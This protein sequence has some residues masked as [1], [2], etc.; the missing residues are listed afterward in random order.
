MD[1][2]DDNTPLV[3]F[4]FE[5]VFPFKF[6]VSNWQRDGSHPDGFRYKLLSVRH[7]SEEIIELVLAREEADGTKT[8]VMRHPIDESIAHEASADLLKRVREQYSLDFE[9]Q[10]Y[11]ACRTLDEFHS[12]T[13][14]FGWSMN[15]LDS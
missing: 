10:D 1:D 6:W 5:D 3:Q 9:E 13:E 2:S 12:A 4:D 14:R 15:S 11:S 8:E 7:R